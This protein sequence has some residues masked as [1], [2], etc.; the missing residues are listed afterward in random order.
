[1]E[2]GEGGEKKKKEVWG[3]VAWWES[4]GARE[5]RKKERE[6]WGEFSVMFRQQ[7]THLN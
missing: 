7:G 3:S 1:M 2:E 4:E 6:Q 5:E